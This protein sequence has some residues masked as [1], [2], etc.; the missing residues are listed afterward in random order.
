VVEVV[1]VMV[2]VMVL[3]DGNCCCVGITAPLLRLRPQHSTVCVFMTAAE[4]GPLLP[5]EFARP[6]I[7]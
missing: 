3:C 6:V 2:M 4:A 7:A 5:L 1:V